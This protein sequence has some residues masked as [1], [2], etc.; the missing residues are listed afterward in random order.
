M[1]EIK[2]E[3]KNQKDRYEIEIQTITKNS[4]HIVAVQKEENDRLNNLI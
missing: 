2:N 4:E 3:L 1:L